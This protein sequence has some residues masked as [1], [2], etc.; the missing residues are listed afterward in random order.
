VLTEEFATRIARDWN[1]RDGDVGYVL[2]FEVPAEALDR[3][4]PQQG[5]AGATFRELWVPAEDLDEFNA[6]ISGRIEVLAEHRS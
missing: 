3:W 2:R 1:A 5:A 6:L 4:P